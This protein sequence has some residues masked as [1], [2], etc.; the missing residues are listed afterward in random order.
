MSNRMWVN[1]EVLKLAKGLQ[2]ALGKIAGARG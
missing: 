2:A 1:D